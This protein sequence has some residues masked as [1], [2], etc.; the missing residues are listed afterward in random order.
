[1]LNNEESQDFVSA[2]RQEL[3]GIA[4]GTML[5][6]AIR[7]N[8]LSG[9]GHLGQ[10]TGAAVEAAA[11]KAHLFVTHTEDLLANPAL[12][13]EVFGP[14]S[15]GVRADSREDMM[16][17]AKELKGHLTATVHGTEQDLLEYKELISLLQTKVGRL[18]INGFPTGVEVA[19][20]M[21]HGGPFPATTDSRSTS[22]GTTAIYRFTRPVCFQGFPESL[23]P[24]ELQAGNPLGITRL[25]DGAYTT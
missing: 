14:C 4:T 8:Y 22:V 10:L 2:T 25:V 18:V 6:E 13:E 17:I 19:H 21:V 7:K 23:L 20:A 15:V 16:R 11:V 5:T 1:M 9:I 12:S 24:P 3:E